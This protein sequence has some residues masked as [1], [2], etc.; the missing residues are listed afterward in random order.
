MLRRSNICIAA[1]VTLSASLPAWGQQ[2]RNVPLGWPQSTDCPYRVVVAATPLSR[3]QSLRIC[4][5]SS[6]LSSTL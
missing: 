5:L 6:L 1:G 2:S 3:V 4:R